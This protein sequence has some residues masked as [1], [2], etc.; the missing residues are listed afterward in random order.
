MANP[1]H[2]R[3]LLEGVENW[4]TRRTQ[5]DFEPDFENANLY[6]EF[7]DSAKLDKEGYIPLAGF[8]LQGANF[9]NAWLSSSY[10]AVGADLRDA[11][12]W[13]AD[14]RKS[15]M[16]NSKFDGARFYG[17]KFGDANLHASS[18][19]GSEIGNT[20]FHRTGL[21]Q[22]DFTNTKLNNA[23]LRDANLS[24]AKLEGANLTSAILT[25][26]DLGAAQPWQAKLFPEDSPA[27]RQQKQA[28]SN[29]HVSCVSDLIQECNNLQ[30]YFSDHKFYFRGEHNNVWKLLSSVR[31]DSARAKEG[32]MLLDLMSRRPEDF[33]NTTSALSQWVLAQ[34][35]GLKTRLLDVTR[36]PLVALFHA[37]KVIEEIG[38][39]HIFSVPKELIKPFNSDS[40]RIITN[41]AKLSCVEQNLLLGIKDWT[42]GCEADP[43]PV[44]TYEHVMRRLYDLIRQEKPSFEGKI[45]PRDFYRVFIVEPQQSFA[46]IRAQAGAFLI[47]AFH[48][49]FE[50]SKVLGHNPGIP[51]YTHTTLEVLDEHKQRIMDELR[52]LN[53]TRE[54]LFPSLDQAAESVTRDHSG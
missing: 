43:K 33:S 20:G 13:G 23:Y 50:R 22:A 8:N 24:H 29:G 16:T 40:I 47:S 11:N 51:I 25:G 12:L 35:H 39:L 6:E 54:S 7:Q 41:F 1:I 32:N 15:E 46:R 34:H 4:N 5:T 27:T 17:A 28:M 38:R 26:A 21:F 3:W 10:A 31:R 44:G 45:D 53:I 49:R 52:L 37:C 30:S 2:I 18:F 36:N 19:C 14:L 9:R 48:E 42:A